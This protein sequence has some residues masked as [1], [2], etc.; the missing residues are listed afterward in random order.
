MSIDKDYPRRDDLHEEDKNQSFI[1]SISEFS[2]AMQEG[3]EQYERECEDY[4]EKLSYEDKLK[5]FYSVCKRIYKADVEKE[6]SYRYALY[7]VFGFGPDAYL[8]GME[9]G[10]MDLHNYIQEGKAAHRNENNMPKDL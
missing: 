1:D 3:A 7:T 4:W 9:C 8:I 6:G 5:A 2:Q 10:Y